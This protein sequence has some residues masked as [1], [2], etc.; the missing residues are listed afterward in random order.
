MSEIGLA[1][2]HYLNTSNFTKWELFSNTRYA[3]QQTGHR[4]YP[5]K[6]ISDTMLINQA[7]LVDGDAR[8]RETTC[9]SGLPE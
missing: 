9:E 3:S 6:P 8:G 4:F 7:V 5:R 2:P 1:R